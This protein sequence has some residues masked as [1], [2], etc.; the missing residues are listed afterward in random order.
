L[1]NTPLPIAPNTLA[2]ATFQQTFGTPNSS[3]AQN[4]QGGL[5]GD[6]NGDGVADLLLYGEQTNTEFLLQSFTNGK[7][8]YCRGDFRKRES[9]I[10]LYSRCAVALSGPL[11]PNGMLDQ[12]YL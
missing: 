8:G 6:L 7:G 10:S 1:N 3:L 11:L 9:P 4:I 12:R 5:A 2:S